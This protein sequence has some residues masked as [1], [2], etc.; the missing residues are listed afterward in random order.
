MLRRPVCRQD[1]VS[2]GGIRKWRETATLSRLSQSLTQSDSASRCG[3]QPNVKL[4]LNYG[5][6]DEDNPY[7]RITVE[8]GS[9]IKFQVPA[10][11]V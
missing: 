1:A 8:V 11:Q 2:G 4:L 7:D 3:P 10:M 9:L 5:F 6:V